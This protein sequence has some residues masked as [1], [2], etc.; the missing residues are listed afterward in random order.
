MWRKYFSRKFL[1]FLVATALLILGKISDTIWFAVACVWLG[2][3]GIL[4]AFSRRV[5]E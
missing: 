2:V 4:D 3:E 5:R 1:V